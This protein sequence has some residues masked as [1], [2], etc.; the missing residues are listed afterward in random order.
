M[1]NRSSG[2]YI[3]QKI[4]WACGS[5]SEKSVGVK[6]NVLVASMVH[7]L[8]WRFEKKGRGQNERNCSIIGTHPFLANTE[9]QHETDARDKA[10]E[11]H[12]PELERFI[13]SNHTDDLKNRYFHFNEMNLFDYEND[14]LE[15]LV[16]ITYILNLSLFYLFHPIFNTLMHFT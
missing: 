8:F 9:N 7:M 4:L 11:L 13:E 3:Q 16:W 10:T 6:M 5:V 1:Q 14:A 2:L 15:D 12:S